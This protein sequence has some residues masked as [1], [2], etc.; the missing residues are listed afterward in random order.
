MF[1]CLWLNS[2]FDKFHKK[3]IMIQLWIA[4]HRPA[5]AAWQTF[6]IFLKIEHKVSSPVT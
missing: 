3:N 6:A 4:W 5:S 1:T 2:A